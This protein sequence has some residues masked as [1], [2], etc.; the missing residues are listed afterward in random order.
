MSAA[1]AA[2]AKVTSAM[3]NMSKDKAFQRDGSLV[4]WTPKSPSLCMMSYFK[5]IS[6]VF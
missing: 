2:A 5:K 4:S 1:T 6:F 3:S